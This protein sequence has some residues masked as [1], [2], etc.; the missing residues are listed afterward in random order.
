MVAR[1]AAGLSRRALAE[2]ADVSERHI[3]LVETT[4]F[5]VTLETVTALAK[6]VGKAPL[7]LLTP[8]KRKKSS[9]SSDIES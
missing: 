2:A 7:E 5:N 8:T 6:H 3:W 9:V 4:A 1:K